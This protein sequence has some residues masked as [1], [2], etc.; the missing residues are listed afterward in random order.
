MGFGSLQHLKNPGSTTRGPNLPASFR[1]QGLVTLLTAY[2]PESRAGFISHRQRSW[3]SPFGGFPFRKV[4]T[5]FR[6]GRTRVPLAGQLFRRREASDRPDQLRFSGPCL[7]KV[8]YGHM[9]F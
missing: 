9:V 4:S 1:L 2:S 3:D 6:P 5:A 8:P 7:P